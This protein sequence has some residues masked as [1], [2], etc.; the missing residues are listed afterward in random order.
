MESNGWSVQNIVESRD[1]G[2]SSCLVILLA[3]TLIGLLLL[4][5][6]LFTAKKTYTVTYVK[7]DD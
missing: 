2:L 4:P 1:H 5:V 6:L 3:L 7:H